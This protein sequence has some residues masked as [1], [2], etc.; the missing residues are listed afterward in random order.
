MTVERLPADM[1]QEFYD[2]EQ[3]M[4]DCSDCSDDEDTDSDSGDGED[5]ESNGGDADGK[6]SER[7]TV[8]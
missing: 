8:E 1:V 7:D 4:C 3:S 5:S 2:M 6:A